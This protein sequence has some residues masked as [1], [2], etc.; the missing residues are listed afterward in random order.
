MQKISHLPEFDPRT[1]Q[2][3]ASRCTEYAIYKVTL[4]TEHHVMLDKQR[5]GTTV[6][7]GGLELHAL[8]QIYLPNA[9]LFC[10]KRDCCQQLVRPTHVDVAKC[11]LHMMTCLRQRSK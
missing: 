7:I 11:L 1:V 9:Y 4:L 3:V 8:R 6:K 10:R 5:V 2:P